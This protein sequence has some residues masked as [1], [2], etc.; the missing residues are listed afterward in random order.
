MEYD[1]VPVLSQNLFFL[2]QTFK[3]YSSTDRRVDHHQ[4]DFWKIYLKFQQPIILRLSCYNFHQIIPYISLRV[5]RDSLPKMAQIMSLQSVPGFK[6]IRTWEF[7]FL[8]QI[9]WRQFQLRSQF[10]SLQSGSYG[11]S[12]QPSTTF[13]CRPFTCQHILNINVKR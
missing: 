12:K 4:L 3:R 11:T 10:L 2:L 7:I 5:I 9:F 6:F 13:C 1:S 8:M